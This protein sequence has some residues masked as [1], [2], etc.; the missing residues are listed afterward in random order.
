MTSQGIED[1]FVTDQPRVYVTTCSETDPFIPK[2]EIN[3][4][5]FIP[6]CEKRFLLGICF[7]EFFQNFF[8]EFCTRCFLAWWEGR[9][10]N[11]FPCLSGHQWIVQFLGVTSG[12]ADVTITKFFSVILLEYQTWIVLSLGQFQD[13][14]GYIRAWSVTSTSTLQS[15]RKS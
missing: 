9:D 8:R 10:P 15:I 1:M 4:G 7:L 6:D 2:C 3:L 13:H 5:T 14:S 11:I 12:W